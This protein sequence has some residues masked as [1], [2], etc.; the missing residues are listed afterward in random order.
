MKKKT[1]VLGGLIAA[2]AIT[3]YSVAGT[4]A[5]Y[6]SSS[7]ASDSAKVAKWTFEDGTTNTLDLFKDGAGVTVVK[8]ATNRGNLV[9][10]G[11]AGTARFSTPSTVT[12][13]NGTDSE[14]HY[15]FTISST[16][17]E[18]T[19]MTEVVDDDKTAL[20]GYLYEK[21]GASFYYPLA[22]TLKVG[23]D[24]GNLTTVSADII[25]ASQKNTPASGVVTL[26]D[27]VNYLSDANNNVAG[28][29]VEISWTWTFEQGS[30]VDVFNKYDSI[31]GR[32]LSDNGVNLSITATA[33]QTT[34]STGSVQ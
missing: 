23:S 10:P 11:T 34:S 1:M 8:D 5:K 3:G 12:G 25:K 22:F 15:K 2:V 30:N 14:V 29:T 13:A 24:A 28:K 4:Y 19:I 33:E 21:D 6:V 18:D 20:S 16:S 7:T 9:A 27:I 17:T 31:I 32:E 26:T